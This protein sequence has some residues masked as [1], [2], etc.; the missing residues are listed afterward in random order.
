MAVGVERKRDRTVA[1]EFLNHLGMDA[2]IEQ[3]G[4]G[5]VSE[6]MEPD[7]RE[8]R[9]IESPMEPLR[10]PG[11]VDWSADWRRKD[12]AGVTPLR[13]NSQ[14]VLNLAPAVLDQS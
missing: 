3:M 11:S 4:G 1:E 13:S 14:L 8:R 6:V 5:G 9:L 7:S 10:G 2:A 12:E